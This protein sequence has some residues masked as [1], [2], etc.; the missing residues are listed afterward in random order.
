MFS[1]RGYGEVELPY[2]LE[3]KYPNAKYEWGWQ[4]V[5]P[6]KNTSTDLR[7][8]AR[9]RHHIHESTLQRA[10]KGAVRLAGITK[11]A[12]CHSFRHSFA[13]HLIENGYDIRTIQEL[14]GHSNVQTT[15]IYTHVAKK[16]KL[17]V[18]SPIDEMRP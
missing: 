17:G 10:V 16:N 2:A 15:M 7:S 11:Q 12:S 8:G 4:Y 13:T 1:K 14:L 5:F 18:K 9:R 3:R 6:A